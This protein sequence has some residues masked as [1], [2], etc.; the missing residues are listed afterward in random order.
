MRTSVAFVLAVATASCMRAPPRFA[1]RLFTYEREYLAQAPSE[2]K[3]DLQHV[4]N[5]IWCSDDDAF[6]IPIVPYPEG[7]VTLR[8]DYEGWGI[9]NTLDMCDVHESVLEIVR[10]RIRPDLTE[11]DAIARVERSA[12]A[13]DDGV[14]PISTAWVV[15]NGRR[16][17]QQVNTLPLYTG[18]ESARDIWRGQGFSY[19]RDPEACRVDRHFVAHGYYFQIAAVAYRVSPHDRCKV[20]TEMAAWAAEHIRVGKGC[21]PRA[22]PR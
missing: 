3:G 21:G 16:Q 7:A 15:Q 22:A 13:V 8:D 2:I 4:T 14:N 18:R 10:T 20:A 11:Q 6:S 17:L 12:H 5:G 1:E 19:V 9:T